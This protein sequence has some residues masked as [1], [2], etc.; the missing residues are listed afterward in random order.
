MSYKDNKRLKYDMKI[1]HELSLLWPGSH[2]WN[3]R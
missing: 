3:E 2:K 1:L